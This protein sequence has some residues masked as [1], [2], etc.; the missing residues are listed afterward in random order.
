M[1][2]AE[3]HYQ[4]HVVRRQEWPPGTTLTEYV[5]GI[6]QV[7]LDPRSGL[8]TSRYLG[9]I[10]L[11]IVR[12]ANELRGPRGYE[13]VLVEYRLEI[14]HW[15]TAHQLSRGMEEIR[16]PYRIELRWLRPLR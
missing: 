8:F 1:T 10:Q 2:A 4:K 6:R 13:Y 16:S 3:R 15:V 5:D 7:I 11:G 12:A 9:A 14:D